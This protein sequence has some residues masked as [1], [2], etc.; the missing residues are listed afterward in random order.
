MEGDAK[1]LKVKVGDRIKF[2][3][4][5]KHDVTWMGDV[6]DCDTMAS[7]PP[8]V[9]GHDSSPFTMLALP[10]WDGAVVSFGCSVGG[11]CGMGQ[12]M[13]IQFGDG[14]ANKELTKGVCKG[15]APLFNEAPWSKV[16]AKFAAC[17]VWDDALPSLAGLVTS[18]DDL[19]TLL[20]AVSAAGLVDTLSG[21]GTFTV[22]A[23]NNK[24]FAAIPEKDLV[25]LLADKEQLKQVILYHVLAS[26]VLYTEDGESLVETASGGALWVT[27]SSDSM[28]VANLDRSIVAN[29]IAVDNMAN[30]GV[31]H[32]IDA[33]LLPPSTTSTS[34]STTPT[35]TTSTTTTP[36]DLPVN[37]DCDPRND[38]CDSSAELCCDPSEYK[39]RYITTTA[40]SSKPTRAPKP[41]T[42]A[43]EA[44]AATPT[45]SS[46]GK[47]SL[48]S[49]EGTNDAGGNTIGNTIMILVVVGSV[50]GALLVFG[51]LKKVGSY[52]ARK[53]ELERMFKDRYAPQ[54]QQN[55]AYDDAYGEATRG[56]HGSR[57]AQ[58]GFGMSKAENSAQNRDGD[59]DD[60]ALL[61]GSDD[62]EDDALVCSGVNV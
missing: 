18:V 11:H 5:G 60:D 40:S 2:T 39:C 43:E 51:A 38:K 27:K 37:S 47:R 10:A 34:T 62:D 41:T 57:S 17:S 33:V 49:T 53:S 8:T 20:A 30:N 46:L 24:A 44:T 9:P 45:T 48:N 58:Q 29:V 32:I 36:H 31:A 1:Y 15:G 59:G 3:W 16:D 61:G 21:D 19:S 23:P 50:V 7:K 26:L 56:S 42:T 54:V 35:T 4:D 22:F 25:A 14:R 13:Q 52:V 28:T 6:S 55:S 12:N